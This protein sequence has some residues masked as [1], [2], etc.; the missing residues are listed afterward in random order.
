VTK[1]SVSAD[2]LI[3]PTIE[4]YCIKYK[5]QDATGIPADMQILVYKNKLLDDNRTLQDYGI[6][7]GANI[8]MTRKL[9]YRSAPVES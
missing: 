9:G 6:T 3:G 2:T 5:I 1:V 8:Y 7:D 4:N